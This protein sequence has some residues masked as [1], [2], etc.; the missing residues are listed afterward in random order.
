MTDETKTENEHP[1][2]IEG[3]DEP[4]GDDAVMPDR[5]P[6]GLLSLTMVALIGTIVLSYVGLN[7]YLMATTDELNAAT[8]TAPDPELVELRA[9]E[10][11]L[12]S[13]YNYDPNTDLYA[14]PVS[15][16]VDQMITTQK[17]SCSDIWP[18]MAP[19]DLPDPKKDEPK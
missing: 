18:G 13:T 8:R 2:G 5:P 10:A 16:A 3:Y 11:T 9:N 7:Q 15:Q 1:H 14:V 4:H 19:R 6:M 12:L 17:V